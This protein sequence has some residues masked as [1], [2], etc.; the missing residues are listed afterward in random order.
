MPA[1]R[2]SAPTS[3]RKSSAPADQFVVGGDVRRE[4]GRELAGTTGRAFHKHPKGEAPLGEPKTN[5]KGRTA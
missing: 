1:R 5:A 2:S 4:D 3:A